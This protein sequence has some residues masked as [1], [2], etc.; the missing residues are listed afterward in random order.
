MN[1]R[2][3]IALAAALAVASASMSLAAEQTVY[4]SLVPKTAKSMA[5][6]GVFSAVPTAEFSFFGNPAAFASKK[7]SFAIPSINVWGYLRPTVDNIQSVVDAT[8]DTNALLTTVMGLVAENG[9][10]GFGASIGSGFAGKGFALGLF[11][12][13]DETVNGANAAVASVGSA[14]EA[15]AIV[16]FGFP[17]NL[18]DLRFQV[19]GD[20]RPFYRVDFLGADKTEISLASVLAS[21]DG[22][23]ATD[24][25]YAYSV[26]GVAADIGATLALG[27]LTFGMSVRDI[28]PQ[29]SIAKASLTEFAN[30]LSSG[31]LPKGSSAGTALFYP[32]IS[33]GV[34]FDPKWK[35]LNPALYLELEDP[36]GV[37][38]DPDANFGSVL[39]LFHVGADVTLF[40]ILSVRGGLSRGW[41]SLGAGVDL[42]FLEANAAVFTE[43]LGALPGDKPRSGFTVEAAVRF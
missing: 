34:A 11:T 41:A 37:F 9:G 39:N 22:G 6:G 28:A 36:I 26:A 19:G 14:T 32:N 30:R 40:K 7:L 3:I 8:S 23:N 13:T 10:T 27:S 17:I 42:L 43:E 5:M 12:T 24:S 15:T 4:S 38:S 2:R 33:A 1:T 35:I 18:G 20:L 31:S 29:Y 21:M 25:L 16:G